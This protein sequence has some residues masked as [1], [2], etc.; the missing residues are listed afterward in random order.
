MQEWN[1]TPADY[2]HNQAAHKL[3]EAQAEKTPDA[4]A[5][6]LGSEQLS[7]RDL[8]LKANQLAHTLQQQGVSLETLVGVCV[9]RSMDRV[10]AILAILKVGGAYVPLDPKYPKERLQFMLQD[11]QVGVLLTQT[12]LLESLPA[13]DAEVICLD[14]TFT[15]QSHPSPNPVDVTA[16]NLAYVIYTSGSTGKPK[17][18]LNTHRGLCNLTAVQQRCFK[19]GVGS[20]VLQFSSPS[21]DASI[22]AIFMALT[23]GATLVLATSTDLIPGENLEQ[24]FITHKISHVL[25]PPSVL[26]FL[27][28]ERLSALQHMIVGG[29][30]CS[31]ELAH[32]WS[33]YC[34]FWNAYGP[35][36]ATV[37]STLAQLDSQSQQLTIGGPLN[38]VHTY[39]LDSKLQ[40]VPIGVPGEL[41]IGGVGLARGYLNR[42]E[43]TEQKF[44]ANPFGP[45]RL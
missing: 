44:I 15:D 32:Q 12:H 29:E 43:L 37:C 8:N 18:V 5:L 22:W 27:K 34:Q 31:L 26:P 35:T 25:L 6:I 30:A 3:F 24:T 20:R 2:P 7:Y 45:G 36:E 40:P 1:N 9:S 17:G 21:F 4:S 19:A 38:N 42:P 28:A 39:I 13:I 10:I 16:E 14:K 11:S 23:S 33:P 41:H